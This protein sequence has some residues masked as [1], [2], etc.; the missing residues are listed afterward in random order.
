[1]ARRTGYTFRSIC[2]ALA[3]ASDGKHVAYVSHQASTRRYYFGM[4]KDI[5]KATLSQEIKIIPSECCIKFP[6]GG[7]L[8]FVTTDVLKMKRG[9]NRLKEFYDA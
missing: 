2:L 3:K 4:A 8:V 9:G 1:M 5:V 7:R 6:N